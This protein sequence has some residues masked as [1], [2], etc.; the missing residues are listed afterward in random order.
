MEHPIYNA[1]L[2]RR[3]IRQYQE[4]PVSKEELTLLVKAAM[5]APSASN[6]RPWS[7]VVVTEAEG[8]DA[9]RGLHPYS[10]Y[11]APAAIVVCGD[12]RRAY[13]GPMQEFWVQDCSAAVENILLAALDLGLGTVWI[14]AYPNMDRAAALAQM[15][16]APEHIRPLGI[17]WVGHP[18]GEPEARTQFEEEQMRW[19]RF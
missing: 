19:E 18:A 17:I 6:R 9:L 16:S 3:S 10:N 13:E 1:I 12:L 15:I 7:F 4:T 14:G 2:K 8:L 11:N 5:A